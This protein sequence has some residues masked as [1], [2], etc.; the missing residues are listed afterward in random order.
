VIVGAGF[1]H[2]SVT[3]AKRVDLVIDPKAVPGSVVIEGQ[4]LPALTLNTPTAR[5]VG[6]AFRIATTVPVRALSGVDIISGK[7]AFEGCDF[8]DA[9][10]QS[11]NIH[12]ADVAPTF[13][14]CSFHDGSL[15]A[16]QVTDKASPAFDTCAII[17]GSGQAIKCSNSSL[18]IKGGSI[19]GAIK[20]SR[21]GIT[22]DQGATI[23]LSGCDVGQRM[24]SAMGL[25]GASVIGLKCH[26]HDVGWNCIETRTSACHV[27]LVDCEIHNGGGDG[28]GANEY[29]HVDLTRCHIYNFHIALRSSNFGTLNAISCTL[30]NVS[31]GIE[32]DN[33]GKV[34]LSKSIIHDMGQV[35]AYA[36][37]GGTAFISECDISTCRDGGLHANKSTINVENSKLYNMPGSAIIFNNSANGALKN[38]IVDGA[39]LSGVIITDGSKVS[40][41]NCS[42]SKL[43][44]N[45]ISILRATG[46]VIGGT[47][48]FAKN[49][50]L[51]AADHS[52]AAV[53]GTTF[54][55]GTVGVRV[56]DQSAVTLNRCTITG[57]AEWGID[58]TTGRAI[59]EDCT[60]GGNGKGDITPS[61]ASEK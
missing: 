8:G 60:L 40:L 3:I 21:N 2:E 57:N 49:S 39:G 4:M 15:S 22:A 27:V 34:T 33:G 44:D 5:I 38:V 41:D 10:E 36:N 30:D 13:R 51:L 26:L 53:T 16:I 55:G 14:M 24:T 17:G 32:V 28:S 42:L 9:A 18:T 37:N 48:K 52:T 12:G 20:G 7:P 23:S 11:V 59:V 25:N 6:I 1:Y 19:R 50:L 45:G 61:V 35:A 58:Q 29:A 54:T 43:G 56:K 46:V 31:E 47:V